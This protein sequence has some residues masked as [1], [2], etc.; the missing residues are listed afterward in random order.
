MQMVEF[1][2]YIPCIDSDTKQDD[3]NTPKLSKYPRPQQIMAEVVERAGDIVNRE[4]EKI[5]RLMLKRWE[6]HGSGHRDGRE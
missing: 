6:E 1:E 5:E 4:E 2:R 3:H